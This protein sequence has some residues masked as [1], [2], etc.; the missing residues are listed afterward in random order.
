MNRK[1]SFTIAGAPAQP[2]THRIVD[3]CDYLTV[4]VLESMFSREKTS[5]NTKSMDFF[6]FDNTCNPLEPT[7]MVLFE[8]PRYFAGRSVEV[9]S[10]I[11]K[12]LAKLKIKTGPVKYV[13]APRTREILSLQIPIIENPT[14]LAAPPEVNMSQTRGYV[15]LRDLLGYQKTNGRYEFAADDLLA[16]VAGVTEE[17]IAACTASPVKG[18]AG[19]R[20]TPSAASVKAVRRCLEEVKLLAQWALAHKQRQLVAS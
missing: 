8:I 12:E 15:V 16:R 18:S 6:T 3:L 17:R 20:R 2:R 14:A 7:G 1:L 9:E 19:V 4:K 10:A 11:K 13:R 5:W